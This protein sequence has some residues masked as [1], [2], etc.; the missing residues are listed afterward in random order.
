MNFERLQFLNMKSTWFCIVLASLMTVSFSVEASGIGHKDFGSGWR[1]L[2]KQ[3]DP[4][5]K[6]KVEI[7]QISRGDFTFLCGEINMSVKTSGFDSFS[8]DAELK[9]IVDGQPPVEKRGRYS[10]YLSGSD[11][12]TNSNYYSAKLSESEVD[13]LKNGR[14][15]KVAGRFSK[16]VGWTTKEL[17]LHGFTPAYNAMCNKA[18]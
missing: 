6:K 17:A 2:T 13:A 14:V 12:V 9:Y 3:D 8:F 1:G 7:I 15:L 10:T 4:F 16:D 11:M 18:K 5:D